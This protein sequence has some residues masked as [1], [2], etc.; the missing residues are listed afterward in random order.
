[1]A[2]VMLQPAELV[3]AYDENKQ[4]GVASQGEAVQTGLDGAFVIPHVAPGTCYVI[5][6][7]PGYVSPL[8]QPPGQPNP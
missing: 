5:A 6:A 8:A 3:D 2:R 1:M 7:M 4:M